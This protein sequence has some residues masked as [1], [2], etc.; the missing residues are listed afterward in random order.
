MELLFLGTS[1]GVPA[2]GRNV[3]ALALHPGAQHATWW[4]FD[5]GEGTQHQMLRTQINPG[6][7]DKI[8]ITHLHGDHIFGLPGLLCSRSMAGGSGPLTLYGPPGL[9]EYVQLSLTMSGSWTDYPLDIVEVSEGV[10]FDDGE[11]EVRCVALNH[12][13]VCFGYRVSA[14]DKPGALDAAALSASGV[15][16]GPLFQ[17]L[18]RGE[19][20]QLED[21]RWIDGRQYIGQPVKGKS[22]AIFGDTAPLDSARLLAAE[23]DML[24]H[25]ATLEASLAQKANSRGHAT[26]VQ[27]ATLAREAGVK[28]L[29]ITHFSSRYRRADFPRLLAEC[30]AIFP[31][32]LMAEDFMQLEV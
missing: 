12:P 31:D 27:A 7:L 9:R 13:V 19:T 17:R 28:T 23:A 25:E 6:K 18:K 5:C 15:P 32:T 3:S 14:H 1:A 26:T 20:V 24:V 30:R 22:V 8:F 16:P 29:V 21:G 11:F 10:I 2:P 4:L